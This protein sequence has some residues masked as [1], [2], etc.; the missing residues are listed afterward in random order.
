MVLDYVISVYYLRKLQTFPHFFI[1]SW[2][3]LAF[4]I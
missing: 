3:A 4:N 1:L 2:I